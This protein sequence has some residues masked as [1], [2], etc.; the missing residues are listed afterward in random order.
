MVED[1]NPHEVDQVEETEV[2]QEP[3]YQERET[4][5]NEVGAAQVRSTNRVAQFLWWVL[6]VIEI[7][8]GLRFVLR[9]I[10]ANPSSTFAGWIYNLSGFFVAPFTG[11]LGTPAA[12][13]IAFD[14]TT[15]IAMLVYF[16][17]FWVIVRLIWIL[18]Y[19]NRS[20]RITNVRRR[21]DE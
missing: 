4:V 20:K 17:V 10:G 13:N 5:V 14:I 21:I 8:L 19:P 15:L 1:P 12:G 7:L 2:T 6:A 3:G 9:L 11:L 16:L 18:F